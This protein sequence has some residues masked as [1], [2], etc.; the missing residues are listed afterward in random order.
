MTSFGAKEKT[1]KNGWSPSVVIQGQVH[2][3]IGSLIPNPEEQAQ[4]IQ[5]YF[6]G[7]TREHCN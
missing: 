6:F 4:Y 5:I 2:H 7:F 3:Y 1:H